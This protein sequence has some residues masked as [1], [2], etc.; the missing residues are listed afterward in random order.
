MDGMASAKI[1][2]WRGFLTRPDRKRLQLA[3][4]DGS[5]NKM[6]TRGID[7]FSQRCW[8]DLVDFKRTRSALRVASVNEVITSTK[9]LTQVFETKPS[10]RGSRKS[11]SMHDMLKVTMLVFRCKC[12]RDVSRTLRSLLKITST[13]HQV[14][15]MVGS[16][17]EGTEIFRT[18]TSISKLNFADRSILL[19]GLKDRTIPFQWGSFRRIEYV[20]KT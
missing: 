13:E 8:I 20:V 7:A 2:T 12:R 4:C 1:S 17:Q 10:S 19:D 5:H 9:F 3:C 14:R 18:K 16:V 15:H 6:K 11:K